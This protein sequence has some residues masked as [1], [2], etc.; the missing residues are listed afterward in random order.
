MDTILRTKFLEH[1]FNLKTLRSVPNKVRQ[2]M[3]N[4]AY[5]VMCL[6]PTLNNQLQLTPLTLF[7]NRFTKKNAFKL[8]F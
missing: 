1:N 2:R 3:I 7:R 8:L 5:S 4:E 6:C